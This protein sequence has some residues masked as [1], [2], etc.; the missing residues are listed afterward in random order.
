MIISLK[1]I[2]GCISLFGGILSVAVPVSMNV[3]RDFQEDSS[4]GRDNSELS[5]AGELSAIDTAESDRLS[6]D[7][8][9]EKLETQYKIS[10]AVE[11]GEVV[12]LAWKEELRSILISDSDWVIEEQSWRE[13]KSI[14]VDKG[15]FCGYLKLNFKNEEYKLK[16]ELKNREWS[17]TVVKRVDNSVSYYRKSASQWIDKAPEVVD[18]DNLTTFLNQRDERW[19]EL[20]EAS[21]VK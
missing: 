7:Q 6:F 9:W 15:I 16:L 12:P 3:R 21:I 1:T 2:L 10:Q 19:D 8:L 18:F 13:C 11:N 5:A 20:S 14:E 17:V 4:I